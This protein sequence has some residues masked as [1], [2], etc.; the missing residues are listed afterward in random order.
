MMTKC[1]KDEAWNRW[2][3]EYLRSLRERCN[4]ENNQRHMEIEIGD[5]A[6]IEGDDKPSG[7]WN[8]T[9]VE[10]YTKGRIT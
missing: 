2:N 9:I 4:M 5:V 7:K 10:Y 1:C 3:K 6:L 8:I